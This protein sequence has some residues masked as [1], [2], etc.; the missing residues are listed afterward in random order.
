MLLK[1]DNIDDDLDKL[2]DEFLGS[3]QS[4]IENLGE[5]LVDI[6]FKLRPE[7]TE[8]IKKIRDGFQNEIDQKKI[9]NKAYY[10]QAKTRIEAR[11]D[12]LM[13]EC[14][15]KKAKWRLIKHEQ[16]L[17]EFALGIQEIQYQDPVDRADTLKKLETYM[18]E[19]FEERRAKIETLEN[20]PSSELSKPRLDQYLDTIREINDKTNE[21]YDV[22]VAKL[23]E[24]KDSCLD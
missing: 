3:I 16:V 1:L 6:G 7:I 13:K 18:Q 19:V 2:D 23:I 22:Y 17:R 15:D 20:M 9:A 12:L 4:N 11:V 10:E 5:A 24:Q 14:E 21:G 8:N